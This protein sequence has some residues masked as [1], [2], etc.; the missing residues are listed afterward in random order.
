MHT[1]GKR[2]SVVILAVSST[3]RAEALAGKL[4]SL[5]FAS[6]SNFVP[7]FA[8]KSAILFERGLWQKMEGEGRC[9]IEHSSNIIRSRSISKS[10]SNSATIQSIF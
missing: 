7:G 3:E 9:I 4:S 10:Q 8:R 2:V 5:K 1:A 6:H